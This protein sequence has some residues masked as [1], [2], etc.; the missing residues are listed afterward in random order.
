MVEYIAQAISRTQLT[1]A[2]EIANVN[3]ET[4]KLRSALSS[5]SRMIYRPS[6]L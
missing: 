4:G 6:S 5:A 3:S 1:K 2:L